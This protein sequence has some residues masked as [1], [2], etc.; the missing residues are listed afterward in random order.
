M[1]YTLEGTL[2]HRGDHFLVI[3]TGGIGFKVF[4]NERTLAHAPNEGNET[5]LFCHLHVREDQLDLYGFFEEGA[6]K[7]FEF[8]VSVSGVGPKTALAVL[9]VDTVEHVMA[10]IINKQ[11]EVLARA[12]GIGKK[13]A[14]RIVLELHNRIVLPKGKAEAMG[15]AVGANLEIEEALAGLGYARSEIRK[16]LSGIGSE[17]TTLEE[18]L[19]QALRTLGKK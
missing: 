1:V 18:R 6:L 19:R 14:E 16:V 13:T 2:T 8:L 12:S 7:L 9:D 17:V 11:I 5:K 4:T 15:E 10:A 3:K